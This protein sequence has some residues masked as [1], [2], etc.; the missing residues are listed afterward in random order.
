MKC[1]KIVVIV[2][3][4]TWVQLLYGQEKVWFLHPNTKSN[5]IEA[6]SLHENNSALEILKKEEIS[7]LTP[8]GLFSALVQLYALNPSDAMVLGTLHM[9]RY[10]IRSIG[11]TFNPISKQEM[12]E[13]YENF[14]LDEKSVGSSAIFY[15]SKLTSNVIMPIGHSKK[16]SEEYYQRLKYDLLTF[17]INA[18]NI[19]IT[20]ETFEKLSVGDFLIFPVIIRNRVPKTPFF[21]PAYKPQLPISAV[22]IT[23]VFK[24]AL[25]IADYIDF[26]ESTK[27]LSNFS[28]EDVVAAFK[29]LSTSP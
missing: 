28:I 9:N 15:D 3:V 25:T 26:A 24:Q 7:Q 11:G 4:M 18:E 8:E 10:A 20:P 1:F 12:A 22:V 6:V 19:F 29:G 14:Q 27:R 16:V 5:S 23:K 17:D 13:Y 2:L 21:N